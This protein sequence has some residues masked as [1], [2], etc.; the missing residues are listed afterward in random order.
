MKDIII[1]GAGRFG[2]EVLQCIKEINDIKKRWNIKGFINDIPDVLDHVRCDYEVIGT[3][4]DWI[5]SKN[6]VFALGIA[7]PEGKEKVVQ[8]LKSKGAIFATIISPG[9]YIS[10]FVTIGEGSV[11]TGNSIGP[12]VV[13][14]NFTWW[15]T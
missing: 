3:I 9:T 7:S 11:I 14:G 12:N 2:R 4:K 1:V 13:L 5:P 6:E 10:D 15:L 8:I